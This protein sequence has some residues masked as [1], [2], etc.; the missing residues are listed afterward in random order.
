MARVGGQPLV[1]RTVR[2]LLAAAQVDEVVVSTDDDEIALAA[3][4]AGATVVHRPVEIAGDTA[5]SESAVLHALDVLAE[6][7]GGDPDL[8][9]LAQCTSPFTTAATVTGVVALAST[10][11]YDSVLTA[12]RVHEFLWRV[13]ESGGADAVNHDSARRPRRQDRAPEYRETG[14]VYAMRTEGLRAHGHRFFGRIGLYE[15]AGTEALEIDDPADLDLARTL[16]AGTDGADAIDVAALVTDFD[17]VHTD[18]TAIVAQDGTESVVVSRADG[19]GVARLLANGIPVL[20]LSVEVNPVVA[21]R[22]A[23]LGV[24]VVHGVGDKATV[25]LKWLADNGLDP[26]RVAYVGNDL[27]DLPC[28]AM[29]G[30]PVAVG[31]ARPE[32]LAAARVILARPGG[33]GAVRELADRILRG[34]D[35]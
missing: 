11:G 26:Q 28:M 22:A 27:R 2:A 9:L 15:V 17:G 31:D 32:V 6:R 16:A 4:A 3:T 14:A 5:S 19:A 8:V 33:H 13:G 25:L 29:V 24:Q 12:T 10:G 23:K 18:D 1:T 20:I 35:L 34:R 21:A 30:W 7:D